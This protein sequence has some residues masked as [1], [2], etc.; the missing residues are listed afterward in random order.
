MREGT[1][2]D[3][4]MTA[5][6][7][8]QLSERSARDPFAA[9]LLQQLTTQAEAATVPDPDLT[10]HRLERARRTVTRLRS[11]LAAAN[12]MAAHVGRLLGACPACWGLDQFCRQCLGAGTPGSQQPD[13]EALVA[14]IAPALH[15]D[16]LRV[17]NIPSASEQNRFPGRS[18]DGS[19]GE[20]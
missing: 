14:W 17:S 11:E 10:D 15:R 2:M 6:L 1:D 13:T 20:R 19:S 5:L 12:A 9:L 16:G 3:P 4:T 7:T 18:D 8:D